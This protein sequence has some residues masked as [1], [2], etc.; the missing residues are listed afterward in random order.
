RDSSGRTTMSRG[1]ARL[2]ST[3]VVAEVALALAL[4]ISAGL[5]VQTAR[6][7]T[8]TDLGFTPAQTLTFRMV[9]DEKHYPTPVAMRTFYERLVDDISGRPGVTGAAAGSLVPFSGI[10]L[11]TEL[12]LDGQ[13]DPKPADTPSAAI[14]Q[15][16]ASY[17]DVIG[18]RVRRGRFLTASDGPEAPKVVVVN[19]TLADRHFPGRDPIGERLR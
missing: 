9:L 19:E 3:L 4:L 17:G 2:R 18:L 10:G 11:D 1:M 5:L 14:N 15:V 13:P 12:F 7:L 6:N 8:R 16:T